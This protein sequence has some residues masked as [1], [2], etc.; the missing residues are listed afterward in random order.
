M[1]GWIVDGLSVSVS[2]EN[3]GVVG[4]GKCD[5]GDGRIILIFY[6]ESSEMWCGR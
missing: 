2:V 5:S 4:F 3:E 6:L 1:G